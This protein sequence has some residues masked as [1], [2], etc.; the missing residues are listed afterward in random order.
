MSKK[1]FDILSP[2]GFPIHHSD[3]YDSKEQA[4]EA[5]EKWL[6][7]YESQGYYSSCD[8]GR[9]PLTEVQEYCT[10]IEI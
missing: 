7:Q 4:I 10:L 2:D 1:Q 6:K 8:H 3:V 9:I 5:F